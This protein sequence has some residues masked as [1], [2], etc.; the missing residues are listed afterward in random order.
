MEARIHRGRVKVQFFLLQGL[1]SPA[2]HT[3][4]TQRKFY[5]KGRSKASL[6]ISQA[7]VE[8]KIQ[9]IR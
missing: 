8:L 9:K 2:Y 6:V 3:N 5:L 7:K 1:N 4:Y